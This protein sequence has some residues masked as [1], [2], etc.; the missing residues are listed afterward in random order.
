MTRDDPRHTTTVLGCALA[1]LSVAVTLV[2][3]P[4]TSA[5]QPSGYGP[6]APFDDA[7]MG[8]DGPVEPLTNQAKIVRTD[9][10][11]RYTAGRQHSNLTVTV[12][13]G[14]LRFHDSGTSSWKSL[15]GACTSKPARGVAAHC[16]VPTGA[17]RTRPLLL[18][19]RPRL[20]NDRVDGRTL[21]AAFEMAV[22]ADAGYDIVRTGAGKDFVNGA[23][24]R[25]RIYAGAG[26]DWVRGGTGNDRL[27]GQAG[28]DYLVGQ[29]GRDDIEGGP[30]RDR[31]YR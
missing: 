10:G 28:H 15:P 9:H 29:D 14:K 22:L 13:H 5:A 25:D 8:N 24:H 6:S 19:I 7:L 3:T 18:E 12:G 4:G 20:G 1:A 21:P 16:A 30:G 17:S 27:R 11:Y 31:I 23:H 26:N 2:L